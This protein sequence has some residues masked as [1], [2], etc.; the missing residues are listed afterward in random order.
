MTC[1][2]EM[3]ALT[4]AHSY[5]QITGDCQAVLLHAYVETGTLA[6]AEALYNA[7]KARVPL[8]IWA[9]TSPSTIEGEVLGGRTEFIQFQQE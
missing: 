1:P 3:V 9:G 7:A 8:L 6:M 2:N 5:A 4:V